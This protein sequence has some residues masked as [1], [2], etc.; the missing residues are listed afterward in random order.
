MLASITSL[1]V[2]IFYSENIRAKGQ[3][4]TV[5]DKWPRVHKLLA[6]LLPDIPGAVFE[7]KLLLSGKTAIAIVNA[8]TDRHSLSC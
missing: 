6:P 2:T 4:A 3:V 8:E 5:D 1:L 7:S